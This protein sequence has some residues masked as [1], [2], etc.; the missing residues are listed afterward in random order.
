MGMS[1]GIEECVDWGRMQANVESIGLGARLERHRPELTAF[2]RR[3]LGP[4]EAED[5]VQE[6]FIRAW[7]GF[8]RFEGR[9]PLR[10]WLY[11]IARNVCLDMLEARQRRAL[12]IDVVPGG[13]P[14]AQAEMP[15]TGSRVTPVFNDCAAA[16]RDPEEAVLAHE[17]LR[18]ALVAAIQHLPPRQRVVLILREV[19][20]WRASE[21]AE[22]LETSPAS[23][24]SA[25]QRAR[26][27]LQTRETSAS[28]SSPTD[29]AASAQLLTR[30]VDAFERYDM[31]ALVSVLREDATSAIRQS[32]PQDA[33]RGTLATGS[34]IGRQP[35]Q[36]K[37]LT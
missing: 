11:R 20:R 37:V 8:E 15:G 10:S 21:V 29:G 24:N 13:D 32:N 3:M 16:D 34:D 4:S 22:L 2:C 14:S 35:S 18:L 17:S 1:G 26:A 7:R 33:A 28:G 31:E 25:L 9:A 36:G 19:L 23:V 27:T 30:Y 5:S 12:P 6:T